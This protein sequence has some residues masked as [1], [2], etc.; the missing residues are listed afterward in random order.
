MPPTFNSWVL[1]EDMLLFN[2]RAL[3]HQLEQTYVG[4]ALAA[5]T[6]R[7][8]ILPQASRASRAELLG[9]LGMAGALCQRTAANP[10]QVP[11]RMMSSPLQP[12]Q[13]SP[14]QFE[15]FCHNAPQALPRCRRPGAE[16]T[17]FPE[18]CAEGDVLRP[19]RDFAAGAAAERGTPLVVETHAALK[20]IPEAETAVL[21]PSAAIVWPSCAGVPL[22]DAQK[23]LGKMDCANEEARA[24][25]AATVL[26][27]P[28]SLNDTH[29]LPLLAP[30]SKVGVWVGGGELSTGCVSSAQ[31]YPLYSAVPPPP[32][33]LTTL[34]YKLWRL[35]LTDIGSHWHAFQGWDCAAPA[36]AF[37]ARMAGAAL[38]W[39]APGG[40]PGALQ[41]LNMTAGRTYSDEPDMGSEGKECEGGKRKGG[42]AAAMAAFAAGRA[43]PAA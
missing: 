4:M 6:G 2:A 41:R 36:L 40:A 42:A 5:A 35:D 22:S 30:L 11:A 34:Q 17:Q 26:S 32:P 31:R 43:Q 21:R 27:V 1:T 13:P 3:Q 12:C 16:A 37:D 23:G 20:G 14:S 33:I 24:P 28:P 39:P 9:A 15:C 10:R 8:F 7:G 19:L 38:P 29:L 25:G 18:P